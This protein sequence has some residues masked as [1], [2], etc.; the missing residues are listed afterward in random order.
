MRVE[1][2]HRVIGIASMPSRI[3][4]KVVTDVPVMTVDFL[5][6]IAALAN[7]SLPSDR[8]FDGM[9]LSPMLMSASKTEHSAQNRT[10][11]HPVGGNKPLGL[12]RC[13]LK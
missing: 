2:G 10:L 7:A 8:H 1:G 4:P 11:F 12:C 6:T 5:P 13:G 3:A 9:D